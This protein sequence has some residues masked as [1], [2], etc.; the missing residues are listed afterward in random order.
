MKKLKIPK[1][2]K[3]IKHIKSRLPM[4]KLE[5]QPEVSGNV[6]R[7]TTETIAEHRE[8]VIGSARKYIYPLQHSKH[9]IVIISISLVVAATIGFFSF[10][11]IALYKLKQNNSFLYGVTRV[12]PFPIAKVDSRFVSYESYLFELRHY[13]HYYQSQLKLDFNS[14]AG[15]NQL[16]DYKKR[17]LNKVVDDAYVK[18]LAEKQKVSVSSQEVNNAINVVRSQN[19]LGDSNS[20]LKDVLKDNF[21]W[22]END[23]K[24]TL[25][26]QLLVQKVIASL[27]V[28]TQNRAKSALQELK[29]GADFA[30]V[31]KKYSDNL[32]TKNNGGDFGGLID[33]NNRDISAQTTSKLFGLKI[34]QYSDIINTGY[35]LE[36]VKLLEVQNDKVRGAQILFNFKDINIYIKDLKNKHKA[37]YYIKV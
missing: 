8:Q 19:R 20:G 7:I 23:F 27:D 22:S 15:K 21:G 1:I 6:E 3:K 25:K 29:N 13:T 10:C 12:I 26:Q 31:T 30:V 32:V 17:A 4:P 18:M 11:T 5:D 24:T 36:I 34:G 16:A 37:Y 2:K 28:D 33:K 14:E 35:S 9:R